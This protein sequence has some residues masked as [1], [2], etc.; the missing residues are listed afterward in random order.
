MYL[1]CHLEVDRECDLW[2][3]RWTTEK[4][5]GVTQCEMQSLRRFDLYVLLSVRGID[6]SVSCQ[7]V[8]PAIICSVQVYI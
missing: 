4:H 7:S 8:C 1:R 5:V 6:L 3:G 2:D